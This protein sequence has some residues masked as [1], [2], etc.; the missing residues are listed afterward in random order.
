[1]A[2]QIEFGNRIA[3]GLEVIEDQDPEIIYIRNGILEIVN[4][5]QNCESVK[6]LTDEDVDLGRLQMTKAELKEISEL[7]VALRNDMIE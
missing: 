4:A 5:Y 7:I 6:N 3:T 1:L 2:S